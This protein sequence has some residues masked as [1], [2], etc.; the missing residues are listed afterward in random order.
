MDTIGASLEVAREMLIADRNR[1]LAN[2]MNDSLFE[3]ELKSFRLSLI[4]QR[5]HLLF[6]YGRATGDDIRKIILILL[7]SADAFLQLLAIENGP[8]GKWPRNTVE[9][10]MGIST[11]VAF[12]PGKENTGRYG[13]NSPYIMKYDFSRDGAK[14]II[15]GNPSIDATSRG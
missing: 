14:E 4:E 3:S 15:K 13:I 6:A 10:K 11:G 5:E 8:L 7:N 1:R 9:E 12:V 2:L